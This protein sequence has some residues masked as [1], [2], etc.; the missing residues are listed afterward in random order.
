MKC[1]LFNKIYINL[2]QFQVIPENKTQGKLINYLI[3]MM[4]NIKNA[5]L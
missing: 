2:Q 5:K 4:K 3:F 1:I